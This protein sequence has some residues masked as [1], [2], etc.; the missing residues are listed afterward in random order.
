MICKKIEWQ[1]NTRKVFNPGSG[2]TQNVEYLRLNLINYY[3]HSMGD[4]DLANQLR[5]VYRFDHWL[6][7][8]K[9]WWSILFWGLGV[10]LVNA[11]VIYVSLNI[12]AGKKKNEVFSHHNFRAAVAYS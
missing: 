6:R 10:I 4:V 12:A 3:N 1:R 7:Q 8:R 11:Y 5:N 9:W 2:S